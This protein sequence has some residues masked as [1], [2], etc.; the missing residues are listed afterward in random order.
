MSLLNFDGVVILS[1][2]LW[3]FRHEDMWQAAHHIALEMSCH[4]PTL[5]VEP[6]AQWNPTSEQFQLSRLAGNLFGPQVRQVQ[7]NLWVFRRRC[8][9]GGRQTNLRKLDLLRNA[10][11]LQHALDRLGFRRSLLWHSFP[12][13][14]ELLVEAVQPVFFAYHCLDHSEIEEETR[15]IKDANIVFSVSPPLA[16]RH[17]NL[18][19]HSYLL[20]NGVDLQ[21]FDPLR[22]AKTPRPRDLPAEGRLIGYA[23]SINCHLDFELLLSTARAFPKDYLV[24]LG[25][26][27]KNETAPR[28]L[29]RVHMQNLLGL[30]NVRFV[31]F[32]PRHIL[33][34]YMK[35]L[36]VCLIPHLADSFNSDR[37]PMK[38]Y[39]Y[40]A[41][42]KP[43]VTTPTAAAKRYQHLCYVSLSQ[44]EFVHNVEAAFRNSSSK[45][46]HGREER[47]RA[48]QA[49]GWS[50]LL[51]GALNQ[52]AQLVRQDAGMTKAL[53]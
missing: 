1:P 10:H 51:E 21:L 27:M 23:G 22:I 40:L 43:V 20:P 11:A 3:T 2:Y 45:Q 32:K 42:G 8:S 41:M 30:P 37:D 7:S 12:Y 34:E 33:P 26:I 50:S 5:F 6:P 36:D 44:E 18:N 16:Q 15:L 25:K 38:L 39:Q 47:V 52:I 35:W 24:L 46:L 53:A 31:G 9:P 49:H 17:A 28:G 4:Y 13:W 29:Q 14:S 19:P 48:M